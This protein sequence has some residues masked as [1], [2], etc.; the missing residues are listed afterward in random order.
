SPTRMVH[1]YNDYEGFNFSGT[2]GDSTYEEY[3]LTSSGYTGGS[4]GPDRC[5]VGA[6]WGDFCGAI[7]HVS[8]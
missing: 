3:P 8:A 5:V 7:T 4:P 1:Q 6:S 2:C